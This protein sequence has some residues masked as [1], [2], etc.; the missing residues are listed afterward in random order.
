MFEFILTVREESS[1]T[2]WEGRNI[3]K[4]LVALRVAF[5]RCSAH[6]SEREEYVM[7]PSMSVCLPHFSQQWGRGFCCWNPLLR[8]SVLQQ[9]PS[10]VA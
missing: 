7:G 3:M 4:P 2:M 5:I 1:E 9:R 6:F 10:D 8:N